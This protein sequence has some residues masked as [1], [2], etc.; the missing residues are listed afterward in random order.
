MHEL[1][2][3]TSTEYNHKCSCAHT[4]ARGLVFSLS[5]E[6]L[7]NLDQKPRITHGTRVLHWQ[8]DWELFATAC[9]PSCFF[10]FSFGSCAAASLV[11]SLTLPASPSV[12]V[13]R[14]ISSPL[15][16]CAVPGE[17]RSGVKEWVERDERKCVY[18]APCLRARARTVYPALGNDRI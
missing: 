8:H 5:C 11:P 3:K 6:V 13:C 17:T 18:V 1:I 9:P 14:Y 7:C 15:A 16:A 10:P 2:N 12:P 4:L